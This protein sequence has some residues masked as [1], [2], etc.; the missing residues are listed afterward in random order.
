M[1]YEFT[2]KYRLAVADTDTD[3]LVE[4]L[5]A[6][7]CED[8]MVG[9]GQPGRIALDFSREARSAKAAIVSAMMTI[10]K[11]IPTARLVELCPS[12]R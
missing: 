1:E 4:R 10:K 7:G 5:G 11:A 2:L 12:A 9:V 8:A 3:E 6:A